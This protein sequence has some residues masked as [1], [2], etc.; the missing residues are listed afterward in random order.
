MTPNFI[1]QYMI[2]DLSVCDELIDIYNKSD[3]K[4]MGTIGGKD[5]PQPEYKQD[6]EIGFSVNTILLN[7]VEDKYLKELAK[8]CNKYKEEYIY[9]NIWGY[10][11]IIENFKLQHYKPN[12]GYH[13]WHAERC[14]A[15]IG[16]RDRH[17]VW[18]TYL[19]DVD[20]GGETEFYYQNLKVKPRKG[21]TLIWPADWTHTHH[22]LTSPTQHKYIMTGWYSYYNP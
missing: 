21:L 3:R 22:G 17:L 14:D 9:S 2:D 19:N 1:G 6:T 7:S 18:M 15:K 5:F 8:C 10:W 4:F 11:K 16:F 20:D 13:I 12:E